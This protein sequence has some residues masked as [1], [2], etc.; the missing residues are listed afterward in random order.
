M[1]GYVA[2][3]VCVWGGVCGVGS[4]C[5]GV[6]GECVGVGVCVCGSNNGLYKNSNTTNIQPVDSFAAIQ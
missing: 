4:E 1:R 3:S 6:G 5:V 2:V